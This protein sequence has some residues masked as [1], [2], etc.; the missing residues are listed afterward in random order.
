[1]LASFLQDLLGSVGGGK[2][3]QGKL[4]H[5]GLARETRLRVK[6]KMERICR[7][8]LPET[9]RPQRPTAHDLLF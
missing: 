1:M 4:T 9:V 5:M 8:L 3:V 7:I 2:L 6:G